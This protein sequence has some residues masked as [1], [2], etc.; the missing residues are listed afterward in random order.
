MIR[1]PPRTTLFPYTSPFRT[2]LTIGTVIDG[3]SGM[4]A[5]GISTSNDD[6]KLTVLAGGLVIG[7]VADAGADDITLG[8]GN[9]TL[10]VVR[11]EEH[12]SELQSRPPLLC[13]LLLET[14][15]L[16]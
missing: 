3:P 1:R 16:N 14:E 15:K 13:R 11:S 7:A 10:N 9:L 12:T 6:V 2:T 8:S 5:S 4:M